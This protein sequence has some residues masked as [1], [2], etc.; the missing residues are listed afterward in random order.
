MSIPIVS[1]NPI[2]V[3]VKT[4]SSSTSAAAPGATSKP[5]DSSPPE[6]G[7]FSRLKTRIS[8]THQFYLDLWTPYVPQRWAATLLLGFL[9][10]LRIVLAQGWYLITYGLGI[11]ILNMFIAF[12]SPK[13]DTNRPLSRYNFDEDDDVG[14]PPPLPTRSGEEFRPF[15]RRLPEFKFWLSTTRAILFCLFLTLFQAFNVPVF[16]P[17]LVM[18]FIIL[19]CATMKRQIKHMIRYRYLPFSHGKTKYQ[20]KED[21]GD[22]VTT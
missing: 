2:P 21:T 12:L 19:F 6:P 5:G 13:M 9:Y 15:I 1:P 11:Y 8:V 20:G 18:Y 17:I 16:W 10:T 7:V 22:V 14:L 3:G 4:P